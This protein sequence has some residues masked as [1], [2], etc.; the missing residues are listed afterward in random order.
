MSC[1]FQSSEYGPTKE[2]EKRA[3]SLDL[4][5]HMEN[6]HFQT[7]LVPYLSNDLR[8][9]PRLETGNGL[10][11]SFR[12]RE[13]ERVET[14]IDEGR[15]TRL[16]LKYC[17]QPSANRFG[18]VRLLSVSRFERNA[19]LGAVSAR[20]EKVLRSIAGWYDR[21][22]NLPKSCSCLQDSRQVSAHGCNHDDA[23]TLQEKYSAEDDSTMPLFGGS[24]RPRL[25]GKNGRSK[26]S[27]R[28]SPKDNPC[29]I[30]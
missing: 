1:R 30:L 21:C 4:H 28:Y 14:W 2:G 3:A 27:A 29:S 12:A 8:R 20:G 5:T 17:E 22:Q 15:E 18:R 23:E 11:C 26:I 24:N 13:C 25:A 9:N 16:S 7:R 6:A 19:G 10:A